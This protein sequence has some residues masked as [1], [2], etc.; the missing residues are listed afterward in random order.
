MIFF[1]I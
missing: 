1:Q